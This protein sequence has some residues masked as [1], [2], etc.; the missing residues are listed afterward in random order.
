MFALVGHTGG[1]DEKFF[2]TFT[3]LIGENMAEDNEE[4]KAEEDEE[5][6]DPREK[7]KKLREKIKEQREERGR[8]SPQGLG[9]SEKMAKMM[10]NMMQRGP[11]SQGSKPNPKLIKEVNRMGQQLQEIKSELQEI[12]EEIKKE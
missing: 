1:G 11:G 5:V 10:G 7:A 2:K 6:P 4:D 9:R 12:K 8:G 3:P